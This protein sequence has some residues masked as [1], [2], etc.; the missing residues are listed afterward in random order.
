[1]EELYDMKL[2]LMAIQPLKKQVV[3]NRDQVCNG[4]GPDREGQWAEHSLWRRGSY[5]RGKFTGYE[6]HLSKELIVF[7]LKAC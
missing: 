6:I 4:M 5:P 1:M 2:T 7:N 3:T